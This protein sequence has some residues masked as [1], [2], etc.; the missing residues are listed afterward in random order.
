MTK[1]NLLNF[2]FSLAVGKYYIQGKEVV[3][4]PIRIANLRRG[5]FYRINDGEA[6]YVEFKIMHQ[7]DGIYIED[8]V[9]RGDIQ[10]LEDF[11]GSLLPE[12][13]TCGQEMRR[14]SLEILVLILALLAIVTTPITI[15]GFIMDQSWAWGTL[16]FL[17]AMVGNI[18]WL[19]R[20]IK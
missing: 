11:I 7:R 5:K 14:E 16:F 15:V 12:P 20:K 18:I 19:W 2:L 17:L 8:L 13:S 1:Q 10:G 9:V 3:V 4:T 6:N